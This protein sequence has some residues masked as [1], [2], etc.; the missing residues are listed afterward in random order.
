ML[1]FWI[2]IAYAIVYY[3]GIPYLR[4]VVFH[5]IA[6]RQRQNHTTT[7]L[8]E[9]VEDPT[10]DSV[11]EDEW[12]QYHIRR[13]MGRLMTTISS[14]DRV[15]FVR[16]AVHGVSADQTAEELGLTATHVY[17]IKSRVLKRLSDLIAQQVKVE[18]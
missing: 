8:P 7:P 18:G 9:D 17:K 3:L 2:R 12:Q 14:R 6:R 1:F 4:T 10:R 5:T 16:Y 15:A 11:F 13:A